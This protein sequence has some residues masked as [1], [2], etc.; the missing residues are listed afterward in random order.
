MFTAPKVESRLSPPKVLVR[1]APSAKPN[2]ASAAF[3]AAQHALHQL[4]RACSN[5]RSRQV[6]VLDT[7][8][9]LPAA[10]RRLRDAFRM[11]AGFRALHPCVIERMIA[12]FFFC[13]LVHYR[14]RRS[15]RPSSCFSNTRHHAA[16]RIRQRTHPFDQAVELVQEVVLEGP[17]DSSSIRRERPSLAAFSSNVTCAFLDQAQDV[18][19]AED[20]GLAMRSGWNASRSVQLFAG[21]GKLDRLARH[22]AHRERRA[23]AGIAVELGQDY[24]GPRPSLSSNVF[25]DR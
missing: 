24:A 1:W 10:I 6:D 9:P 20:T 22:R 11:I 19:H 2:T 17:A 8:L 18:A 23:A 4:S 5:C 15:P 12:S 14:G 13:A 7:A 21:A 25:R 16:G 3:S